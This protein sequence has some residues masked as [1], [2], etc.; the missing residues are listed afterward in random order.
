V[1]DERGTRGAMQTGEKIDDDI[2]CWK[3]SLG[4]GYPRTRR[5]GEAKGRAY[6]GLTYRIG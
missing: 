2:W 6:Y 1:E 4:H 5:S 3:E